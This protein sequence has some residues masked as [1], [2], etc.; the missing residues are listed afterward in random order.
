MVYSPLQA[1]RK[2]GVPVANRMMLLVNP[3]AGKGEFKTVLAE[4]LHTICD[5]GWL[6]TVV[7]TKHAGEAPGISPAR[8]ARSGFA[9]VSLP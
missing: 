2:G 8:M 1:Y 5:G 3:N 7:F 9:I 6:P 4:I